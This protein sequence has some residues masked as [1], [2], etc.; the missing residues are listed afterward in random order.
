MAA[1]I[2]VEAVNNP[3]KFGD[4]IYDYVGTDKFYSDTRKSIDKIFSDDEGFTTGVIAGMAKDSCK[5][6]VAYMQIGGEILSK[7]YDNSAVARTIS[8]AAYQATSFA[9]DVAATLG[10]G[11]VNVTSTAC[12]ATGKFLGETAYK[13]ASLFGWG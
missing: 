9:T 6:G 4:E 13:A 3:E 11:A 7:A 5:I 2:V 12:N 8:D 10:K 1:S